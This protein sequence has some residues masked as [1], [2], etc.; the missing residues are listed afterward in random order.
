MPLYRISRLVERHAS[1]R[2][3]IVLLLAASVFSVVF[4]FSSLPISVPYFKQTSGQGLLDTRL[5]YTAHEAFSMIQGYGEAGRRHYLQFLAADMMFIPLYSLG[6]SMLITSL[7]AGTGLQRNALLLNLLPLLAGSFDSLED[8]CI[9]SMLLEYP[10]HDSWIGTFS[11]AA[12]ACKWSATLASLL[13]LAFL[14]AGRSKRRPKM[15]ASAIEKEH[16]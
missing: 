12:T 7:M 13:C 14:A 3:T 11:G 1:R 4:N 9:L 15:E 6:F 2:R 10:K 16:A 8:A 5:Y